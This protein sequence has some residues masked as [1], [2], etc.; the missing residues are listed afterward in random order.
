MI[1]QRGV[2]IT[3]TIR[4]VRTALALVEHIVGSDIQ[5]KVLQNVISSVHRDSLLAQS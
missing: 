1:E 2:G 4:E 3:I 5:V